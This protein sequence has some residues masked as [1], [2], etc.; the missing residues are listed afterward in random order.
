[1]LGEGLQLL[2]VVLG[3]RDCDTVERSLREVC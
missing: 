2:C 1:M 3:R